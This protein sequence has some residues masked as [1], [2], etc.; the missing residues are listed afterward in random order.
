M[1]AFNRN[2][3]CRDMICMFRIKKS[4]QHSKAI[5]MEENVQLQDYDKK[6]S[7]IESI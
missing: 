2:T 3:S 7:L 1:G 4:G 6:N 5:E